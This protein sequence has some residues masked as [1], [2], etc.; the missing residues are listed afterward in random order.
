MIVPCPA[1]PDGQVWTSDGPTG[2]LCPV[3]QGKAFIGEEEC[4][5]CD[6]AGWIEDVIEDREFEC[7]RCHG[8]GIIRPE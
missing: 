6:G 2:R 4:P 1:C 7:P 5:L 8:T 3:C